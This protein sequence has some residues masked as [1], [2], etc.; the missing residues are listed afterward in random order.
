M[1]KTQ[2]LA[3]RRREQAALGTV[4]LFALAAI[5]WWWAAAGGPSGGLV[6]TRAEVSRDIAFRVDV[7]SAGWPELAQLPGIGETL[8]RRIVAS[9]EEE[10]P[11]RRAE[12]LTRVHGLGPKK[13]EAMRPYLGPFAAAAY[14]KGRAGDRR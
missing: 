6:E 8:S 11:F 4:A 3:L 13:L 10:G 7:N 2:R 14:P 9:R 12:D 5:A 1:A